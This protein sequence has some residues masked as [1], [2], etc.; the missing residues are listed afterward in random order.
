VKYS[1]ILK[2]ALVAI[3][4][5]SIPV[6]AQDLRGGF[7]EYFRDRQRP[8]SAEQDR[9]RGG[10]FDLG[11]KLRWQVGLGLTN[12]IAQNLF[13]KSKGADVGIDTHGYDLRCQL[14]GDRGQLNL[15]LIG[16]LAADDFVDSSS[17]QLSGQLSGQSV[18]KTF[19]TDLIDF[20][21][22]YAARANSK[23]WGYETTVGFRYVSNQYPE[24][25]GAVFSPMAQRNWA[26]RDLNFGDPK[27][28]V[29]GDVSEFCGKLGGA[30][31][32]QIEGQEKKWFCFT[33]VRANC[34]I[35][36]ELDSNG[37]KQSTVGFD[38]R[39]GYPVISNQNRAKPP[40]LS[41][42]CSVS[43]DQNFSPDCEIKAGLGAVLRYEVWGVKMTQWLE[44][45]KPIERI[46]TLPIAGQELDLNSDRDLMLLIGG[47]FRF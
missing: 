24:G 26:H 16:R 17:Q 31:T 22:R 12:D 18:E 23:G 37:W 8:M 47:S 33:R 3:H 46:D 32:W 45:V 40:I 27:E 10:A 11:E 28:V 4:F 30:L 9:E 14:I 5:L 6:W 34:V 25:V 21:L 42:E 38:A 39:A 35:P 19:S 15:D 41:M 36:G 2:T 13:G 44:L 29:D 7:E 20:D 1:R 43:A